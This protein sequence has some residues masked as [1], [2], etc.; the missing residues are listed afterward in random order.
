MDQE[1]AEKIIMEIHAEYSV[2]S[3]GSKLNNFELNSDCQ[4]YFMYSFMSMN[5]L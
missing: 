1:D 4:N 3:N 5:L 2:T